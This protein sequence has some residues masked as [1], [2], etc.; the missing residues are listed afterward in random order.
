MA[1]TKTKVV[2]LTDKATGQVFKIGA[3]R[4]IQF[5]GVNSGAD[6]SI[7][8]QDKKNGVPITKTVDETPATINTAAAKTFSI[9]SEG[10]TLY[11]HPD[12]IINFV[13]IGSSRQIAYDA[14]LVKPK[15]I[16]SSTAA[17]T[18]NTAA[19]NTFTVTSSDPQVGTFY[20]N[21]NYV[22]NITSNSPVRQAILQ[23]L[24][25]AEGATMVA[26]GSGYAVG[27]T[28]TIDGGEKTTAAILEVATTKLVD[29]ALNAAGAGYAVNDTITL[30][31]GTATT[32]A[33]ITVDAVDGGGA[34]TDFSIT[35]A[36][37]Y[38]V[39][40]TSFT[41]DSTS[42]GGTGA[43]FNGALFG[44]RTATID[45][46]GRYSETPSNPASQDTSSGSGT[47][48]TFTVLYEGDSIVVVDGGL[49]Y[50]I[51]PTITPAG[52]GT[53]MTAT[54]TIVNGQV[55]DVQIG[56]RGNNYTYA[57]AEASDGAGSIIMYDD[58]FGPALERIQVEET[59]SDL[60]TT[61][62]AL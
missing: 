14:G 50:S 39:E 17:A 53:G 21:C 16:S 43:T 62:N 3:N 15:Y 45:T 49:N 55:N 10:I 33:V 26:P 4:I 30:A 47:G 12:R 28:I 29:A 61:I 9:T 37:N 59:M 54:A 19:A 32:K 27:D 24:L 23:V 8:Y 2:S 41:Q 44:V 36:G 20:I 7:T 51:A 56:A 40:T 18:I 58:E 25:R 5:Y 34:I 48:A 31:G 46:P 11:I 13:D 57:T 35:N 6:S 42:G 38:T 52:D 22:Y 60:A 1:G